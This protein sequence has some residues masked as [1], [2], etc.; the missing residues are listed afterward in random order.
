MKVKADA[1]I[2]MNFG[3]EGK[4]K[5]VNTI[6]SEGN[7][8]HCLRF[9]GG[10][11][12]GHTVY[13]N[14]EKVVTHCI[15]TGVLQGVKSIIGTGC[16]LNVK[17]F[18]DEME[19]LSKWV[20]NIEDL[21]KIAYNCHIV[22]NRH[23]EEENREIK[24]GTT[25]Q[26]I[27]PAYREKYNR[28][29]HRAEDVDSLKRFIT[30][31]YHE[32]YHNEKPVRILCE[33][34]Q[35]FYLDIDWGFYPYCTSSHCGVGS[36]INNGISYKDINNIIG[37]SKCYETYVGAGSFQDLSDKALD[38]IG[39]VGQEF[40]ATTGRKRQ[41]NYLNCKRL[42]KSCKLNGASL[43]IMNKLDILREVGV[44]KLFDMENNLIDLD[45]EDSFKEYVRQCIPDTDVVFSES[46]YDI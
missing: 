17:K 30:D 31:P 4:A 22:K 9:N 14:G 36:I 27:G 19:Y 8:T 42:I 1:I 35:A 7:Y 41:T 6:L 34:A 26:G 15:P 38:R 45:N 46:P 39:E 29:G 12:A 11:N 44:W 40:G 13:I 28:T 20:P 33:G 21:V 16:V 37:V 24:I 3:D 10:S 18:F 2:G 43:V 32:F 23:I 25:K 5:V